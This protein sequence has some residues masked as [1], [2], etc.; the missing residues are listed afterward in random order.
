MIRRLFVVSVLQ[1]FA[2]WLTPPPKEVT[3]K[4]HMLKLLKDELE[5]TMALA[6]CPTLQHINENCIY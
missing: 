2:H 4:P 3:A 1:R 6:G 5:I